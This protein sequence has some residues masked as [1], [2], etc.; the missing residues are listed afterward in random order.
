MFINDL[1]ESQQLKTLVIIPG[2]FHPFHPGHLSLYRSAQKAFP[3]AT[4]VY[5]ATDDQKDRP[6][7]FSDKQKLAQIAGVPA[8]AFQL[9]KSPFVAKEITQHFDP[10]TTALVFARSE[11]DRNEHPKPGG[12]KKDG[13]PSYL[14][15]YDPN[16]LEPMSK[17]GY[18]AYLPTVQFDAG[19]SGVTSATQ[20]RDMWPKADDSQKNAIIQDLYPKNPAVA[21]QILDKNLGGGLAEESSAVDPN[22]I[23]LKKRAKQAHPFAKDENEALLLYL[24]DKNASEFKDIH[25]EQDHELS[26]IKRIDKAEGTVEKEIARLEQEINKIKSALS[27]QKTV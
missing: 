13:S 9:V 27:V 18:M 6:F 24:A 1:F 23:Q 17:H 15:P 14:Q 25:G 2:G 8:N 21:K 4:I 20:I 11:K 10:N 26:M 7:A 22:V 16:H 19:P 3:G 12:V 5:A